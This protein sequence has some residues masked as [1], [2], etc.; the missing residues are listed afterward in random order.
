MT[1]RWTKESIEIKVKL[2]DGNLVGGNEEQKLTR[3]S[4]KLLMDPRRFTKPWWEENFFF[5]VQLFKKLRT[6]QEGQKNRRRKDP[7]DTPVG[8]HCHAAV[9]KRGNPQLKRQCSQATE[10]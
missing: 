1:M 5:D 3:W 6:V 7:A 8:L 2:S 10:D 4:G 9:N